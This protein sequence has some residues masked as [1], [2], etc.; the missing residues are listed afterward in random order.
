MTWP[1]LMGDT[2]FA[3]TYTATTAKIDDALASHWNGNCVLSEVG[4][5]RPRDG[6]LFV[7]FNSGFNEADARYSLLSLLNVDSTVNEFNIAF[8][9][10]Y[11]INQVDQDSEIPGILIGR[12]PGDGYAGGNPWVLATAALGQLLYRALYQ[13][14]QALAVEF[15]ADVAGIAEVFAAAGDSVMHTHTHTHTLISNSCF[16]SIQSIN[17]INIPNR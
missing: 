15:P 2:T 7:G 8:C 6:S 10:E 13:Y 4:G 3:V 16:S 9:A 11:K 17:N 5:D 12:Y 1:P 14:S